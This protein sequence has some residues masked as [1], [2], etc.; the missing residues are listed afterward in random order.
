MSEI[1]EVEKVP[2]STT[3]ELPKRSWV[4]QVKSKVNKALKREHESTG[5]HI[6]IDIFYSP[7]RNEKDIEGLETRFK[8][9]DIFFPEIAGWTTEGL[10][11]YQRLSKGEITPDEVMSLTG[12]N[13]K[14]PFYQMRLK[15]LQMIHN[16]NKLIDSV[17]VPYGHRIEQGID[18][19]SDVRISE[20]FE[21]TL[22]SVRNFIE[23]LAMVER[24]R[25][26]YIAA[27]LPIRI[28]EILNENPQLKKKEEVVALLHL[29]AAHTLVFHDT[30]KARVT[31]KREFSSRPYIFSFRDDAL[32]RFMLNKPISKALL[33]LVLLEREFYLTMGAEL[34]EVTQDTKEYDAVLRKIVSPFSFEEIKGIFVAVSK[35]ESF[36]EAFE[37][38]LQ[39]KNL[40]IPQSQAELDSMLSSERS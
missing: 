34:E 3:V 20:N 21:D 30:R 32:R 19:V 37:S 12:W 10:R 7:H 29:G 39:E 13:P 2:Q 11:H 9:A 14:Q 31:T 33:S 5:P 26:E 1:Q 36:P 38:H 22:N 25:E 24:E 17:D 16:S 28:K 27:E 15:E 18:K 6:S 35:G 40:K 4:Q 23:S 8:E